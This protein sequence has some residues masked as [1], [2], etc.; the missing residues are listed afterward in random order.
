MDQF[1]EK[2]VM[3]KSSEIR[4]FSKDYDILW[5]F[6]DA[7]P[8]KGE[9]MREQVRTDYYLKSDTKNTGIKVREGN[10][11]LKVKCAKDETLEYGI[12][13]HWV[14]WST[15]EKKNIL[16]TIADEL[17]EEWVPVK[18]MRVKKSYEI[19]SD[20]KIVFEDERYAD[21]GVGVEFTEV[22]LGSVDQPLYTVGFE[23]FSVTNNQR[24]NL[25]CLINSLDTELLS[26]KNLDSYGYP[27]MLKKLENGSK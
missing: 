7:L 5:D 18:K 24:A 2:T 8:E 26:F 9:E 19:V 20:T 21:E 6:F 10:H 4:W 16:N 11:E 15:A 27:Q 22:N 17:L 14:K 23:S 12:M 13:T 1:N 3:F 25:M